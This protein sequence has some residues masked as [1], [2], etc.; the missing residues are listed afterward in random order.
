[1]EL[2]TDGERQVAAGGTV[3]R[4]NYESD[5]AE[6]SVY[7]RD[8]DDI[9]VL[10]DTSAILTVWGDGGNDT[11]QVGQLFDSPRN[12]AAGLAPEDF[13]DTI[14]TTKGYLS[15][16][17]GVGLLLS[18]CMEASATTPLRS[19]TTARNSPSS[20]RRTMTPSWFVPL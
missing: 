1:M 8:G 17:N 4:V 10:D 16:G 19:T 2:G 7:G 11:F 13:F 18:A 20:G 6:L 14:L 9:F 5:I 3:E 15:N 12:A